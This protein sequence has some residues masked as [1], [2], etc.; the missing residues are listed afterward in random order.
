MGRELRR[1]VTEAR[2]GRPL[3][4]A[5]DGIA[6]PRMESGDFAWAVDGHPHPTGG[7]RQPG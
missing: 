5:L 2:L 7:R 6:A 3:E 1:V 4:E